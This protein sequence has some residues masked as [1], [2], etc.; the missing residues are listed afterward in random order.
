[1]KL[2]TYNNTDGNSAVAN[3][4]YGFSEVAAIYPIT[5]SSDM[6][7]HADAWAAQGRKNIFWEPV[8]VVQMQSEGG[9]A[10]AIHGAL[11]AGAMATTFTASQG[12]MLMIPNMFKIAGE[13]LPVVFHVS[14]RSLAC[15]ALSIFGDHSD[16]MATR[17]TGFVMLASSNVQEAQDLAVISHLATLESKIPF[18]HFFDGFRTSHS[19]Q[20]IIPI[21]YE[22]MKSMV[23]MKFVEEF[24][25]M[26]LKPEAPMCKVGAQNPDVYFQGR[27]TVNRFYDACPSIIKK[28]MKLFAEKTG[29]EY[30][31][32]EYIGSPDAKKIIIAMGS[33][34]ETIE[35]TINYLQKQGEK[36]GMLKVRLYRPFVL[37]DFVNEIPKSVK[38]IAVLDRT[39]EPGSLGEPL[40]LD[41]VAALSNQ[42]PG[43]RI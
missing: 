18:L 15:Q 1:M 8:D 30:K 26:A 31:L 23:D 17:G 4:A 33:S 21:G 9:A 36:V 42:R 22:E 41:V 35:E 25:A 6:G 19:I 7:E 2:N 38:R 28:H 40:Y 10:G 16:V 43:I 3:V 24:R 27:E 37:D 32:Y 29:R 14:A 34:T 5:P 39:K 12:L 13:L 20:K 11:S